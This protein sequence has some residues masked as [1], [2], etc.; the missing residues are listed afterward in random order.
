M[1]EVQR[2]MLG[3]SAPECLDLRCLFGH[4]RGERQ[5]HQLVQALLPVRLGGWIGRQVAQRIVGV[6]GLDITGR[7]EIGDVTAEG[8]GRVGNAGECLAQEFIRVGIALPVHVNADHHG[9][10]A[11]DQH[12]FA[13]VVAGYAM[14]E[15][16]QVHATS[17][18]AAGIGRHVSVARSERSVHDL[19][20]ACLPAQRRRP[21]AQKTRQ[22]ATLRRDVIWL[23]RHRALGC[24]LRMIFPE[25]RFALFR[26][27]L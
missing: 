21:S 4:R 9:L 2:L 10:A 18:R 5:D 24:C 26:I 15:F 12:Q 13:I 22:N 1:P 19:V 27:M 20:E 8:R 16:C 23:D 14:E 25:N 17:E 11:G 3:R 7:D 6:D